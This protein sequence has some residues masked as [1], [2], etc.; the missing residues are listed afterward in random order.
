MNY[1]DLPCLQIYREVHTYV[2]Q[3]LEELDSN[4]AGMLRSAQ[5]DIDA[6]EAALRYGSSVH[7]NIMSLCFVCRALKEELAQERRGQE[8]LLKDVKQAQPSQP[9]HQS[10]KFGGPRGMGGGG[11]TRR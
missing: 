6:K 9:A 5:D 8:T 2:D 7:I 4:E 11:G 1:N 3:V 10:Q